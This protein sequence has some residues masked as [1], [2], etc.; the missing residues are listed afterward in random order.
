MVK[1]KCHLRTQY[2]WYNIGLQFYYYLVADHQKTCKPFEFNPLLAVFKNMQKF[3]KRN[4]Q[5]GS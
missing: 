2:G 4:I 3:T 1:Y 5:N